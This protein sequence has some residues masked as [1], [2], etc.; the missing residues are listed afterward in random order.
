MIPA[1]SVRAPRCVVLDLTPRLLADALGRLLAERGLA[2][3]QA[4]TDG[5]ELAPSRVAVAVIGGRDP[6]V[7][8]A[9]IVVRLPE[10]G[11]SEALTAVTVVRPAGSVQVTVGGVEGLLDLVV[12]LVAGQ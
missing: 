4:T 3:T 1:R 8:H 10:E 6:E 7:A 12:A 9:E 2:V 5:A 11:L